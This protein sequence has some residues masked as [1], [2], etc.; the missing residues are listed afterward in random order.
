[1][2]LLWKPAVDGMAGM[3]YSSER[4]ARLRQGIR[5]SICPLEHTGGSPASARRTKKGLGM[6]LE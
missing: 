3:Q 4:D 5:D 2:S 6:P 1:M